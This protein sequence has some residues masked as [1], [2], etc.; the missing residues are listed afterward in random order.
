VNNAGN[1]LASGDILPGDLGYKYASILSA[2]LLMLF[3]TTTGAYI[4]INSTQI[5]QV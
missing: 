3:G 2:L 5:G 4:V 1:I